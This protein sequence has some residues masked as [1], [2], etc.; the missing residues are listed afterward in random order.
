MLG[1]FNE[2]HDFTF[3]PPWEMAASFDAEWQANITEDDWYLVF[4]GEY[5]E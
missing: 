1:E 2:R 5:E 3:S 4:W